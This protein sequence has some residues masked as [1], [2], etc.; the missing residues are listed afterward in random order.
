MSMVHFLLVVDHLWVSGRPSRGWQGTRR[1]VVGP[2]PLQLFP[3]VSFASKVYVQN[4]K[5]VVHF[6]IW[7]TILR[8]VGDHP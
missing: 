6:F 5:S 8:L 7:V 3:C 4:F 1:G 2:H